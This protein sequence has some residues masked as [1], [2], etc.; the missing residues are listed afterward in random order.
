MRQ[1]NQPAKV[2][3]PLLGLMLVGGCTWGFGGGEEVPEMH[4]NLSKTVDIQ[5]AVVQGDLEK[6]R[7][8][9]AWLLQ[10][11]DAM[12]VPPAGADYQRAMLNAA[13]G[14]R[15]AQDL[16]TMAGLTGQLA[17]GC[18]SCH[19]AVQGGPRF[20]VGNNAP[21]GTS[22]EAQMI[23]HL[24]AAD[25]MWEGLVGPS[26]EAW[27]A[28]AEAMAQTQPALARAYKASTSAAQ[29]GGF[30]GEVNR[31][32]S[33]ALAATTL[34]ER[35]DVYGRLLNTCNRCHTPVGIMVEK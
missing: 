20:V 21:G 34:V 23:R 7:K 8:G 16:K 12:I 24:W 15:A 3:I 27:K 10:R 22:Q 5:T 25:R 18:G 32:A 9:A 1:L 6:A 28:G 31:L 11:E 30:L 26:D 2:T 33:E 29:S 4:R 14:I 19:Q 35:A 17:G 13:S